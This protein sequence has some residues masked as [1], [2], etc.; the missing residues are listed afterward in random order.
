MSQSS[1]LRVFISST[2]QDLQE[3]REHLVKKVFP[4]V[5]SRCRERGVTFTEVDLRWG[6]TEEDVTSGRVIRTCLE[7]IDRTRPYFIGITGDRYGFVPQAGDIK[8]DPELLERFP[9]IEQAL[10]EGASLTDLE[11]R[12]GALNRLVNESEH[13]Q[14]IFYFRQRLWG[15]D[16]ASVDRMKLI[17]LERRVREKGFRMHPYQDA[18]TLGDLVRTEL[19]AILERDF[20]DS[21]PPTPLEAE[22]LKHEAFASSRRHAYLPNPEYV[23]RLDRFAASDEVPLV[24]YAESGAGKSS[25][26]AHWAASYRERQPSTAVIEHY[27]GIGAGATDHYGVMRHIMEEIKTR[28]DRTE[29]IPGTP[30]EIERQFANWLG[31]TL[32][33]PVVIII[34]G[35]NQL[36]GVAAKLEWVPK[37]W[38]NNIRFIITAATEETLNDLKQRN[39][40]EMRVRLLEA[41]ERKAII[42]Q[43]L[44]EYGKALASHEIDRIANDPKCAHPLFLRTLLEELRIF[45]SHFEL[46]DR[47]TRCLSTAGTDELFQIVLERM[48]GDFSPQQVRDVMSLIW[49]ARTGL[50]EGELVDVTGIGRLDISMITMSLDYHLLRRDGLLTFFHDFL[51]RAVEARY[52]DAEE[53]KRQRHL[54]L[55][56]YFEKIVMDLAEKELAESVQTA[57]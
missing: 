51:R 34:D 41:E 16:A 11:F 17:S 1:E 48:E 28:Y 15:R 21:K 49:A 4:E 29:E 13:D 5:R 55:A 54:A 32:Q 53:T 38:P 35:V 44:R 6:V 20:A 12:Y 37:F 25:L 24:I 10:A 39:W 3:E 42:V 23:D 33:N 14:C 22:R 45:G 50:A 30:E 27:I 36:S 52:L 46:S 8:A 57:A 2:F 19:L 7:E 47:V 18:T 31:F 9:W 26:V 40:Q 56:D 43:F